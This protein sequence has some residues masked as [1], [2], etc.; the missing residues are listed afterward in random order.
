MLAEWTFASQPV[1]SI[2]LPFYLGVTKW[3]KKK[4]PIWNLGQFREIQVE[5]TAPRGNLV[6]RRII[7]SAQLDTVETNQELEL[8]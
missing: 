5:I 8:I 7:M 1:L 3:V 4:Y 2:N 6:L